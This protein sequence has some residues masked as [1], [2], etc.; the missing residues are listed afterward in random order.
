MSALGQKRTLSIVQSMSAL[1]PKA[2]IGSRDPDVRFVPKAD[3]ASR[4]IH[5]RFTHPARQQ[6]R[7]GAGIRLRTG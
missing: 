5:V 4:P 3:I 7:F 2:D 1:P 6:F